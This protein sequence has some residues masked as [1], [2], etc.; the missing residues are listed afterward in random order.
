[1]FVYNFVD[2]FHQIGERNRQDDIRQNNSR[3]LSDLARSTLPDDTFVLEE[4]TK[5]D[6][7]WHYDSFVISF[8]VCLFILLVTIFYWPAKRIKYICI[9]VIAIIYK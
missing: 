8:V 1:M 7:N 3:I 5:I 9:I 4:W 6:N 2:V